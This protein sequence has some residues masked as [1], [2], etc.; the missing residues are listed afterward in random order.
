MIRFNWFQLVMRER[1]CC[2]VVTGYELLDWTVDWW[3]DKLIDNEIIIK[4][5]PT[6]VFVFFSNQRTALHVVKQRLN[7]FLWKCTDCSLPLEELRV[8]LARGRQWILCD[9]NLCQ[10]QTWRT[11]SVGVSLNEVLWLMV[12]LTFQLPRY[13]HHWLDRLCQTLWGYVV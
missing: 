4:C 7:Y 5:S 13:I 9:R 8:V 3:I 11:Q 12:V 10:T 1:R 6:Q 2:L